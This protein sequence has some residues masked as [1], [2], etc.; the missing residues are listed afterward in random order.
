MGTE[1]GTWGTV[2]GDMR[3]WHDDRVQTL[4]A[5]IYCS[6]NLDFH[7]LGHNDLL[8]EHPLRYTLEPKGG[9]TQ[10][11]YR[12]G[13]S[14]IWVGLSYAFVAT[15]VRFEAPDGT[16]GLPDTNQ[17]STVGGLTP[18]LTYDT[19]DNIFTTGRGTYVELTAGLFSGALGGDDEFQRARLIAMQFFPFGSRWFLGMRG[20]TA[21]SFGDE[22]FYLRPFLNLRGVPI[23]RYQGE[24]M[25]QLEV[26]ARWQFWKRFS[27]VG[28]LGGGG[29]W[30]DFEQ[31]GESLAIV[32]GGGGFRY[33]IAREYGIHM[34]ADIA[35][36]EDNNAVYIQVGSAWA[37]P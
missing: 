33:E 14:K 16:P 25:A 23:M 4:A 31:F 36:S 19:R 24:E 35:F 37:R 2:M 28:F 15:D 13:I 9:F 18:S 5:L 7:G 21:A 20:E 22:P 26:E 30:N 10:G 3:H 1:N 32:A 6:V 12:L 17:R 27:L 29:V 34:G 11:K 8:S